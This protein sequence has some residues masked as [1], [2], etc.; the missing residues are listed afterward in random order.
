MIG[1][2]VEHP[3]AIGGS[4]DRELDRTGAG[5]RVGLEGHAALQAERR[6]ALPIRSERVAAGDLHERRKGFVQPDPV[7]PAHRHQI[8]EPHVGD[9][10]CDDIGEVLQLELGGGLRV[11]QQQVLAIGDAAQV[12]HCAG[13]EIGKSE[14][15]D[16]VAGIRD[17]VVVLVVPQ[18]MGA[19]L[20]RE[21]GEV[22]LARYVND[23]QRGAV[24]VDGFRRFQWPDDECNEIGAHDHR[25]L[26]GH[27]VLAVVA[28]RPTDLWPV[29]DCQK[30][31]LDNQRDVE[32]SF[33]LR[34]VEARKCAAAVG[35][36]HLCRSDHTLCTAVVEE[37]TAIPPAQLVVER[38]REIDVNGGVADI[39]GGVDDEPF[40]I[41]FEMERTLGA[42]DSNRR[43]LE[44]VGVECDGFDIVDGGHVD[45]CGAGEGGAGK[46]RLEH[47]SV[48]VGNNGFGKSVGVVAHGMERTAADYHQ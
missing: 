27:D 8:A 39:D 25:G 20:E 30:I 44:L 9:L 1:Q 33:E 38:A 10:V 47:Q 7:P 5:Q 46:I 18:R 4:L 26:E 6:P 35:G 2:H 24:D 15:V 11:G 17:S 16:L 29:G 45:R 23:T 14:H 48:A 37:R 19:D 40:G 21:L 13:G 32:D 28:D 31:R 12:L 3:V 41:G 42:A 36:L 34:L 43:D 22:T